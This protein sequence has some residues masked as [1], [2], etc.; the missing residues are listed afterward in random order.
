[1]AI[2]NES[3][4]NPVDKHAQSNT[5][6]KSETPP[7]I[8]SAI[9]TDFLS[10]RIACP[11]L[12]ISVRSPEEVV[13]V[14]SR[15]VDWIDLKDPDLGPL[16]RPELN[17][18][19]A[20]RNKLLLDQGQ[21]SPSE[22][23]RDPSDLAESTSNSPQRRWSVAGG[24][25]RDWDIDADQP[26]LEALG[27]TGAIKWALA[28]C[29][30]DPNWQTKASDLANRLPRRD[31]A[32]LVH[33]ADHT[34]VN[35]PNWHATLQATRQL[36]LKYLLIDTAIKDGRTL[37]DYYPPQALTAMIAD[38]SKWGIDVAIAGSIPLDSIPSLADVGAAWIGVRG[39][40]CSGKSR[41]STISP[42]KLDR[43]VALVHASGTTTVSNR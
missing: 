34:A 24:E 1:M 6:A 29:D 9:G 30:A 5:F 35:A 33:Y 13:L 28:H 21:G 12:L 41:S 39:A 27:D 16:G 20:F 15:P 37:I 40:V 22:T 38:A 25:L 8:Q 7:A 17:T 18:L 36:N 26:Y 19:H 4:P 10:Q 14:C 42:E 11:S 2:D 31:Q 3:Q 32:I 23:T 43:A